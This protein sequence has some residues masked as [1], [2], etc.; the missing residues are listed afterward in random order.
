M[1]KK[2][3]RN[4]C[5]CG[6]NK[7]YR[8]CCKNKTEEKSKN[9][10]PREVIEYFMKARSE[11]EMMKKAGIHIHYVRPI[12]FQGKKVFALGNRVYA[13]IPPTET[14]HT[15]LIQILKVTIGLDWLREQAKLPNSERH[16]ISL[17]LEKLNEWIEKNKKTAT[18]DRNGVWGAIPDGYSKSLLSLAFDVCSLVHTHKLPQSLIAR[19]KTKNH[20][21]GARYEITIAS[22]FARLNCDIEWTDENSKSKHCEFIATHRST[23]SVL[24][25]EVKSKKRSGVLHELG[26]LQP[27]E[28]LYSAKMVRRSLNNALKQ[29]P[30]DVPF[31]VFI[32]VNTPPTPN[33]PYM[34]KQW[35]KDVSSIIDRKL[36]TYTPEE[37]PLNAVFFTN[38]SYHYQ[39]EN[40]AER[41][42]IYSRIIEHPK[43]PP[44]N[45]DF[46]NYLESALVH[47]GYVPNIDVEN[48]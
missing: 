36:E 23:G 7:R 21:Q 43:F 20:Y 18:P 6:S 39:T 15:F 28:K 11:Q 32:D 24:A 26:I 46:F 9:S 3:K 41:G 44:P 48:I 30:K 35:I 38:Y 29:N 31:A 40:E 13:D 5:H 16:Y 8:N 1:S 17:C 25:V 42:E 45:P 37:Y 4:L 14:F 22:I 10:I 47:Y 33:T 34:D 19:L 12:M 27:F 2:K